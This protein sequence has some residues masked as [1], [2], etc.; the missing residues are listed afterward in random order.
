MIYKL[1]GKLKETRGYKT[2]WSPVPL[3]TEEGWREIPREPILG[4]EYLVMDPKTNQYLIEE[5]EITPEKREAKRKIAIKRQLIAELPDIILQNKD[6]PEVLAQKLCSRA[7]QI[8]VETNETRRN[9]EA[10]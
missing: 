10:V 5:L 2:A 8:E 4:K 7:K 6:N 9:P 3:P 1:Y